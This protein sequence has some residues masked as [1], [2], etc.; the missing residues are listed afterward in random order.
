MSITSPTV[1]NVFIGYD[2]REAIAS[3]VCAYSILKHATVPVKIHHIKLDQLEAD[4]IITREREPDAS[5]EFTYTRFLVPYLMEYHG[6]AIFCDCDFVWTTDIKELYDQIKSKSIYVVDHEKHGYKPKTST[7]M[8]GK[9]Q[10]FYPRKNWS[11]M[12]AFDCG[13]MDCQKLSTDYINQASP[14]ELHRLNWCREQKIGYVSNTWNWLAGYYKETATHKPKAI[15]F[16]DGG[17]WFNDN[18]IPGE[19][20]ITSWAD[21]DYG[22]TWLQYRDEYNTSTKVPDKRRSEIVDIQAGPAYTKLFKD[23]QAILL[24][25]YN[26]YDPPDLDVF[27]NEIKEQKQQQ[28][29]LGISDMEDLSQTIIKKGYSWDKVVEAVVKGAGGSLTDWDTVYGGN[30]SKDKRPI[31]FRGITKKHIVQWCEENK[32]DY[33]FIDTGYFGNGKS[34]NWHRITKNNLQYLGDLRDVSSDRYVKAHGYNKKFTSGSKILLCPPSEKAMTFY[35]VEQSTWLDNT[36]E[37]IAEYTDREV[38]VRLKPERKERIYTNTIQEALQDDVHC[39]VTYNSIVAVEAL[40]EG[41][42]AFVLGQNA[43]SPLC[44]NDLSQIEAI[45][46]PTQEEVMYLLS[47]LAYHQFNIHEISTGSAWVTLQ[48]WYNT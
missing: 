9:E 10:T 15:H 33:Y 8:D 31:V 19:M 29:V 17:P 48:Q 16:T 46:Y 37:K 24:D 4:G 20:E 7:K 5:T 2:S 3:E 13:S 30:A 14:R 26:I 32:R 41:K 44:S 23:L 38:V 21:V 40:M 36:L 12:M 34:K 25:G 45:K 6:K 42:P 11:S 18:N 35:G 1:I 28:G 27:I 22:A 47:N 39:V 43:A